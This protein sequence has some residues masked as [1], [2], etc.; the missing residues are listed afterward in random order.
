MPTSQAPFSSRRH[1]NH[2]GKATAM[3]I[4][5]ATDVF[6]IG[7]GPAGLAAAIAARLRGFNV[8]VADG[9]HPPIDKACGEGLMPD[10]RTALRK[11]DVQLTPQ[12][13]FALRGVRFIDDRTEAEARFSLA[14]V[15][16][17]EF[18]VG[19]GVR[20]PVLHRRMIERAAS[21]GVTLFWNTPVVALRDG[22]V[23]L[24]ESHAP[25][26][27][28][29]R[30]RWIVG[31]DGSGSRVR[32][33]SGLD[34]HRQKDGRFAFRRHYCV[35]PWSD[36]AEVYW[37]ERAQAYVT[38]VSAEEICVVAVTRSPGH[39]MDG[40]LREF[41]AL[42]RK[43][44][45]AKAASADRGAVTSMHRLARVTCGNLA[46]IGDASG[47]VDAITGEG[48]SLS[49]H[50]AAALAHALERENLALYERSH[51]RLAGRPAFM[52]RMML[53]LDASPFLRRRVLCAFSH[54][55][56][57]FARLLAA[58]IGETSPAQLA[59]TGVTLGWRFL[60]A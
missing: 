18:A 29:I 3:M 55:P 37:G 38:P 40:A 36:C 39:R 33:W 4:P 52:A 58:H 19:I 14:A 8:T 13:G 60:V 50:Q 12:D 43:L 7:G 34:A 32:R 59:L 31:A 44:A 35:K 6:V 16:G 26:R 41:P 11:L 46:L 48:L 30:A 9:S 20:R 5:A 24:A 51:R 42:L 25:A 21:L 23:F 10:G 54:D 47:S 49:F 1:S 28:V 45:N 53:A 2:I 27:S 17:E 56:K 15:P 22:E 57:I